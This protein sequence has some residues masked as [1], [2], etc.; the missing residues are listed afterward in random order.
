MFGTLR[1]DG[2]LEEAHRV[3]PRSCID[4]LDVNEILLVD[5]SLHDLV[6]GGEVDD[7]IYE[8]NESC[9]IVDGIVDFLEEELTELVLIL[10]VLVEFF[11]GSEF[12]GIH[13]LLGRILFVAEDGVEDGM[14]SMVAVVSFDNLLNGLILVL[15]SRL[16]SL[17]LILSPPFCLP[18]GLV[19]LPC[20]GESGLDQLD[21]GGSQIGSMDLGP[22]GYEDV[23]VVLQLQLLTN[24]GGC[25]GPSLIF[26]VVVYEVVNAFDDSLQEVIHRGSAL[27]EFHSECSLFLSLRLVFEFLD[28]LGLTGF[29]ALYEAVGL[30]LHLFGGEVLL[31]SSVAIDL[32]D[33]LDNALYIIS[34]VGGSI[35]FFMAAR[36]L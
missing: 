32:V 13:R 23:Y 35:A 31:L 34:N 17:V 10:R 28:E 36:L 18:F 14:V 5:H 2:I 24:K 12:E 15:H 33:I 26:L 7:G 25:R 11:L 8:F 27:S 20:L 22:V 4:F 21:E 1:E 3:Q 16:H 19:F 9:S 6:S 29:A 30:L